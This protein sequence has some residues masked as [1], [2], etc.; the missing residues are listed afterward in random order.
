MTREEILTRLRDLLK[1]SFEI[2]PARVTLDAK[3]VQ[4]L[5]LDSI[6]AID[7]VVQ[8][9]EWT[10]RRVPEEALRSI[11]TVNDVVTI[12][13]AHL[14]HSGTEGAEAQAEPAPPGDKAG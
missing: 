9:E 8:L 12:V 11:S 3:L 4:D 2:D 13:E 7:M 14:A 6:D 1:Q 5:E 10:G